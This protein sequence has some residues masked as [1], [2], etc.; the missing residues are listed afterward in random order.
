M[1][2]NGL[3]VQGWSMDEPFWNDR[4]MQWV[5]IRGNGISLL[6]E[7]LF[8]HVC[9][10]HIHSSLSGHH[11]GNWLQK[12]GPYLHKKALSATEQKEVL[13]QESMDEP[14]G[15][16]ARHRQQAYTMSLP[17]GTLYGSTAY[18]FIKEGRDWQQGVADQ[19]HKIQVGG[20]GFESLFK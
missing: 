12:D 20:K 9:G 10:I 5:S 1:R 4:Y 19:G 11:W 8:S 3:H 6:K 7:H 2:T 16:C 18:N 17:Q 15:H 13:L 14:G